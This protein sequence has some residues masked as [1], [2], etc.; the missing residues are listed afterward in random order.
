MQ[1]DRL[2]IICLCNH[3]K[4]EEGIQPL[5]PA[6]FRELSFLL[7]RYGK[8]P[9]SLFH[10]SM[11]ELAS[12]G[13]SSVDARRIFIL[14]DRIPIIETMLGSYRSMGIHVVTSAELSY[15]P[16]LKSTLGHNCPPV[17]CYVGD[18]SLC[19]KSAIGFV[20]S[21]DISPEDAEFAIQAVNKT[22]AQ[23]Y[24]IVSGGARGSDSVSEETALWNGGSVVEFPAV[25]LLRKMRDPKIVPFLEGNQLLLASP[26]APSTGFSSALATTRNRMIYAHSTATI[27][28]RATKCKGGT[29]SGAT[30]AIK[31]RLCPVL[32][33]D[34]PYEGNQG[35]LQKGAI[36]IDESWDGLLPCSTSKI[37]PTQENGAEIPEQF[38]I[39]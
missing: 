3:F 18:L 8:T 21:R 17:L 19:E 31:H 7:N 25:P 2:A 15:F 32:C 1:Q 34:Y 29:W 20:G 9:G 14:L 23:G 13:V 30:D 27:V 22:T 4:R 12:M 16:T 36:P 11:G 24:A 6:E 37:L 5:T 10:I 28:I 35:L 26:V 39:F 33:R 38:S